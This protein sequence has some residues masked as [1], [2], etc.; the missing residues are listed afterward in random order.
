MFLLRVISVCASAA[1]HGSADLQHHMKC[2][3]LSFNRLN[4]STRTVWVPSWILAPRHISFGPTLF[5]SPQQVVRTQTHYSTIM[6]P[7]TSKQFWLQQSTGDGTRKGLS[8]QSTMSCLYLNLKQLKSPVNPCRPSSAVSNLRLIW[9]VQSCS[10]CLVVLNIELQQLESPQSVSKSYS[11]SPHKTSLKS[12]C[13]SKSCLS[14]HSMCST[15]FHRETETAV[16]ASWD[17]FAVLLRKSATWSTSCLVR[18]PELQ[19][20]TSW[21]IEDPRIFSEGWRQMNTRRWKNPWDH[22]IPDEIL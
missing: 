15:S 11:C 4:V 10:V 3:A 21:H 16:Q 5:I 1:P 22:R 6:S 18:D 12:A 8:H 19:W 7:T 9:N 14:W 17:N 2:S 20:I 13:W